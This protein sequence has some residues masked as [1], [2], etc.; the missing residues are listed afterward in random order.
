MRGKRMDGRERILT[1]RHIRAVYGKQSLDTLR[2][3]AIL[4]QFLIFPL[5]ALIL[6]YGV[7]IP[8]ME[9][10]YFV[11][12]FAV[13]FLGMAPLTAMSALLSEEKETH[14]LRM[15]HLAGVTSA[16]Y[17]LGAGGSLLTISLLGALSFGAIGGFGGMTLLRFLAAM[18]A[19][20]FISLLLGG[21]I[22]LTAKNQSAATSVTV[23]V[24][25]VFS[26]LPMLAMFN[27]AVAAAAKFT[28]TGQIHRFLCGAQAGE[29]PWIFPAVLLGNALAAALLFAWAYRHV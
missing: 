26:F 27:D 15:L 10:H 2:N 20:I 8:G 19:G 13:M 3:K 28:Y 14:T 24:M 21:A 4:L 23:P 18:T 5:M 9:E 25:M 7:E 29:S 12:L 1:G 16:E 11:H 22:G 17:L 6:E